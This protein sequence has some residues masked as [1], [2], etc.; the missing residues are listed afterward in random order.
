MAMAR[1]D[2]SSWPWLERMPHH[3]QGQRRYI[4]MAMVSENALSWPWSEKARHAQ[5]IEGTSCSYSI[6]VMVKEDTSSWPWLEKV[7]HHGHG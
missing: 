7:P 5:S 2:V 4:I 3:G 6:M 1:E